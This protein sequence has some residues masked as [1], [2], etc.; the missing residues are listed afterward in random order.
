M[1]SLR[2]GTEDV[3][4][5]RRVRSVGQRAMLEGENVTQ[6]LEWGARFWVPMDLRFV[7]VLGLRSTS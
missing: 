4:T 2:W 5:A 6:A 7:R 1:R 3:A